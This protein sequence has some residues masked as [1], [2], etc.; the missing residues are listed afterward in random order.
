MQEIQD[1]SSLPQ[2]HEVCVQLF[3]LM[4]CCTT[5]SSLICRNYLTYKHRQTN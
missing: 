4:I 3:L 1:S 5:L 2:I